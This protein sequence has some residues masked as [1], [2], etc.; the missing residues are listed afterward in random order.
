MGVQSR[1]D[2]GSLVAKAIKK[3]KKTDPTKPKKTIIDCIEEP[4]ADK[5]NAAQEIL[6][7][8]WLE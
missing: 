2:K 5:R 8:E 1:F 3:M 4:N 7:Q 6:D